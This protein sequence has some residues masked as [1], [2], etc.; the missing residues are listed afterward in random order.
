[1]TTE[2]I[3][4]RKEIFNNKNYG[5]VYLLFDGKYF[6]IGKTKNINNRI[7]Q[8]KSNNINVELIAFRECYGFSKFEKLLH[9][10]YEKFRYKNEWFLMDDFDNLVELW[11]S[12]SIYYKTFQEVSQINFNSDIKI[13]TKLT[14]LIDIEQIQNNLKIL[15]EQSN[16]Y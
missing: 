1:M 12:F 13:I 14:N 9:H 3:I 10:R 7:K 15:M 6:K 5:I 8:I 16:I 11:L 4:K 2:E